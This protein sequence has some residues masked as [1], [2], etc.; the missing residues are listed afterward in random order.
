[1]G[2]WSE[3]QRAPFLG[4]TQGGFF[5]SL[6]RVLFVVFGSSTSLSRVVA[7]GGSS[8]AFI[9]SSR[10]LSESSLEYGVRC[11]GGELL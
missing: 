11:G 2:R 9:S 1:M 3:S 5:P 7:P 10:N 4:R 6:G 8:V